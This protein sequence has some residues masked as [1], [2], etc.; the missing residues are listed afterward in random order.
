M[1][2]Q[3][4]L[5]IDTINPNVKTMEYAVRGPIFKQKNTHIYAKQYPFKNVIKANI[6]DCHAMGQTP[7]TLFDKW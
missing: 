3:K 2:N 5:T 1:A 7:I 6:G 4:V